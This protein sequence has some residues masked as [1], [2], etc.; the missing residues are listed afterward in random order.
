MTHF[1]HISTFGCESLVGYPTVKTTVI[2]SAS[3]T[4]V[5]RLRCDCGALSGDVTRERER[6]RGDVDGEETLARLEREKQV[7]SALNPLSLPP[8][9]HIKQAINLHSR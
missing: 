9:K 5:T 7:P 6:E 1:N 4:M 2:P 3:I 8:P